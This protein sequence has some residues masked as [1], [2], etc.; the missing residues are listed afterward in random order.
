M[1]Y[2][3]LGL[4]IRLRSLAS[5]SLS[6]CADRRYLHGRNADILFLMGVE[7]DGG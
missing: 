7:E 3:S 2:F 1:Q 6:S 4:A 5:S